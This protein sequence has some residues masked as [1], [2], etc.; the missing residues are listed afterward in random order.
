MERYRGLL[1]ILGWDSRLS[2]RLIFRYHFKTNR[3]L[4]PDKSFCLFEINAR[5]FLPKNFTILTQKIKPVEEWKN[6]EVYYQY[7]RLGFQISRRHIFPYH[8]KTNGMLF[9]DK[10]FCFFEINAWQL[11]PKSFTILTQKMK[12]VEE[13]KDFG[14]YCQY[15]TV[16]CMVIYTPVCIYNHDVFFCNIL[17]RK[18]I[19]EVPNCL[20]LC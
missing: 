2:G 14:L 6:T 11:P 3:M 1:S 16:P 10:S 19:V 7:Y 4:F 18:L 13:W 8:F 15:Y 5:P 20:I 9:S 17:A 12:P